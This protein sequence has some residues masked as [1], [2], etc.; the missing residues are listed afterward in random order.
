MNR[1]RL[2]NLTT[3]NTESIVHIVNNIDNFSRKE[4]KSD[5][6]F[7][8]PE[9]SLRAIYTAAPYIRYVSERVSSIL[10]KYDLHLSH[11]PSNKLR[12]QLCNFKDRR[13]PSNEADVVYKLCCNDCSAVYI[14]KR[15]LSINCVVMTVRLCTLSSGCCL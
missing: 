8:H 4:W 5:T 7:R 11:K 10:K 15:V 1:K 13:E 3:E 9:Q 14:I 6:N 2:I 12:N